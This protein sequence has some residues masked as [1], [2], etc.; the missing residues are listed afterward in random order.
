M[1]EL[2]LPFCYFF[3]HNSLM[4]ILQKIFIDH[5]EEIEYTLHPR[6]TEMEN[7][8]K[9]INCGDPSYTNSTL[10]QEENMLKCKYE[11]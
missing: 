7:I 4:N 1:G 2:G 3:V 11:L 8:D 5:Y 10:N 9:M 6:L